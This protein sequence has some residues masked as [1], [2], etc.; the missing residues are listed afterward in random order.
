MLDKMCEHKNCIKLFT[1]DELKSIIKI[2]FQCVD[3]EKILKENEFE[4]T[5]V[6]NCCWCHGKGYYIIAGN[7]YVCGGCGR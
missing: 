7:K 4:E 2:E 1:T 6:D 3:C 5:I